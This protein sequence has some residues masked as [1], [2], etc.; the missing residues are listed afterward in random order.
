MMKKFAAIAAVGATAT[1]VGG[2]I[3]LAQGDDEPAAKNVSAVA[4]ASAQKKASEGQPCVIKKWSQY[5]KFVGTQYEWPNNSEFRASAYGPNSSLSLSVSATRTTAIDATFGISKAD[6]GA[7]IGINVS[8]A[9][10]INRTFTKNLTKKGHYSVRAG[11]VYK[12]YVFNAYET[13]GKIHWPN[14]KVYTCK[15]DGVQRHYLGTGHVRWFW[16]YDFK[17]TKV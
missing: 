6:I 1:V 9:R 11:L 2:T 8:E 4:G 7:T 5:R 13:R 12:K 15:W 14:H 17:V 10:T 3:V 16:T